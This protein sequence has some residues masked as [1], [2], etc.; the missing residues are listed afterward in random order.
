MRS[1]LVLLAAACLASFGLIA[2]AADD[3]A[4]TDDSSEINEG[5]GSLE[6]QLDPPMAAPE[7]P[8]IGAKMSAVFDA[9]K[10]TLTA[11]AAKEGND[12]CSTTQLKNASSKK[13]M[14]E[15][16]TCEGSD[17]IRILNDDG[18]TK[19]EHSDLNKDG[20]VDRYTNEAGAIAQYTDHNFDGKVDVIVE[21]VDKLKDFSMKGY[22]ETFPKAS[23][24]YRVR[25]DRNKDGKLD[26]EKLTARGALPKAAE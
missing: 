25:E 8:L 10:G 5:R 24:L 3:G 23:F 19:E 11:G 2:C 18:T 20:E 17:T 21:R 14:L 7:T 13:V 26:H 15:R 1:C 6:R 12:G 4:V 9:A 16:I 22:E